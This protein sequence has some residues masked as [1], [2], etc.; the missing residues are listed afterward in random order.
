MF[1]MMMSEAF[2]K[3]KTCKLM[4][5]GFVTISLYCGFQYFYNSYFNDPKT[6]KDMKVIFL[7]VYF[8]AV[9]YP[10][11]RE[12]QVVL[13]ERGEEIPYDGFTS[14]GSVFL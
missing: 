6:D 5:L 13:V 14:I 2:D 7:V 1:S 4:I 12:M 9:M 11:L 3:I 8:V 10:L